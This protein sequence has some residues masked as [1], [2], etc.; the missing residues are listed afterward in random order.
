[1]TRAGPVARPLI[2]RSERV[3]AG[4][5]A[6]P[7]SNTQSEYSRSVQTK[8]LASRC[9]RFQ[10]PFAATVAGMQGMGSAAVR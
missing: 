2:V 4:T 1:M 7:A 3:R 8:T 9:R 5:S 6:A 10:V